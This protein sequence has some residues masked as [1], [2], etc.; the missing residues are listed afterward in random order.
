MDGYF[1]SNFT[2][3]ILY[4]CD[5]DQDVKT[6][7]LTFVLIIPVGLPLTMDRV[8]SGETGKVTRNQLCCTLQTSLSFLKFSQRDFLLLSDK[9]LILNAR[10][11]VCLACVKV[12]DRKRARSVYGLLRR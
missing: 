10:R 5:L 3:A 11:V 12:G 4:T 7:Q 9:R 6:G 8:G 2:G 1:A